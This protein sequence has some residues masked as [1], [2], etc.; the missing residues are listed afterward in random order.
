M[1]REFL[2]LC[3]IAFQINCMMKKNKQLQCPQLAE[4]ESDINDPALVTR[5]KSAQL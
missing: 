1:S 5:T 3:L 2:K 4:K